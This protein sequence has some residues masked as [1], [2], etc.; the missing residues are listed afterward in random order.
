MDD[1]HTSKHSTRIMTQLTLLRRESNLHVNIYLTTPTPSDIHYSRY[2]YGTRAAY[3]AGSRCEFVTPLY[4][5]L[6]RC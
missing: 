5:N 4:C 1:I 6:F 2:F 3:F